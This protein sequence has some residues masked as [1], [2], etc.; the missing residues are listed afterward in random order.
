MKLHIVEPASTDRHLGTGMS[1]YTSWLRL[2]HNFV[3]R[4]SLFADLA[5]PIVV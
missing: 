4:I 1:C 5:F 2:S 3:L